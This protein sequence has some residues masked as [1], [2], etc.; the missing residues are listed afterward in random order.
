MNYEL[1]V[2]DVVSDYELRYGGMPVSDLDWVYMR[3]LCYIYNEMHPDLVYMLC[4]GYLRSRPQLVEACGEGVPNATLQIAF[5]T[6]LPE[7]SNGII[8]QFDGCCWL[9]EEM[10]IA[11]D[12][13]D[14]IFKCAKGAYISPSTSAMIRPSEWLEKIRGYGETLENIDYGYHNKDIIMSTYKD[15]LSEC[16]LDVKLCAGEYNENGG[17]NFS[18]RMSEYIRGL[19]VKVDKR[20]KL[21]KRK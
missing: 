8:E 1:V 10:M 11:L 19:H 12:L 15:I 16:E 9:P 17:Y 6:V 7:N 20:D 18:K 4:M 21:A 14:E 13:S 3:G 2:R 5:S